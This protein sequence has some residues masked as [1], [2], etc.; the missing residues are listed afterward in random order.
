MNASQL[1]NVIRNSG[2]WSPGMP[3]KLDACRTG[4]GAK[5]IAMDLSRALGTSV[6]APNGQSSSFGSYDTGVWNMFSIPGTSLGIGLT[7]GMWITYDLGGK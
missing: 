3:I 5:N 7:P 2:Q 1:A 4:R 6:T